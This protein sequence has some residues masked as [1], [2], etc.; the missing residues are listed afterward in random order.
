MLCNSFL[1]NGLEIYVI[2]RRA[3]RVKG[4]FSLQPARSDRIFLHETDR[5]VAPAERVLV[6]VEE[7]LDGVEQL[8]VQLVHLLLRWHLDLVNMQRRAE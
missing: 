7:C 5:L 1:R 2:K 4:K 3:P 6:P 8:G